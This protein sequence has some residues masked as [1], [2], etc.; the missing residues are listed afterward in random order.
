MS[1]P[2]SYIKFLLKEIENK[3]IEI[4][5]GTKA[6]KSLIMAM[7]KILHIQL[8][9]NQHKVALKIP[10]KSLNQKRARTLPDKKPVKCPK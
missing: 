3:L 7:I 5:R 4:N 10:S 8:T 2:H 1:F 9:S 6:F